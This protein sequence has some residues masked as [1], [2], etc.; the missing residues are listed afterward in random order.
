MPRDLIPSDKTIRAVRPGDSRRRLSDGDGLYLLLFVKGGSHGWRFDYS[1]GGKRKTLS[2]GVYPDTGLSLARKKAQDARTLLQQGFDPSAA[3]REAKAEVVRK[4]EALTRE[5]AGLPPEGSF[6]AVARAWLDNVHRVDCVA[7][8]ADRTQ[9]RLEQNVFPWLGRRPIGEIEPPEL[10]RCLR[11]IEERGARETA[12]RV[13]F[14]CSQVF[15]YG[16]AEG[17]CSRDPASDLRDALASVTVRHHAAIVDPAR[18]G[19]LLRAIESYK[20][21][22]VTRAALALAPLVFQR[23]GELR[24]A[25]WT[26]FDLEAATWTIPSAR[27]K[28]RK[29]QKETGQPHLV[30]LSTQ[31]VEILN[32]LRPLTGQGRF[33][34]P[35]HRSRAR[36]MSDAAV[37]AA[38][39]RMG[40]PKDE[41]SGHGFRAMARTLLAERLAVPPEVIEAQLAHHVPDALG[42]AYNRALYV[43]Q[44]RDMMQRWADYLDRLRRGAEVIAF[45][46]ASA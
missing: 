44:R 31:A 37:L 33:V 26:E 15:R 39:R 19:E 36:P 20:G 29:Q 46:Q 8:H 17:H 41:M 5:A 38:L 42:R 27:M 45:K 35:G 34:F 2:L 32:D 3:R 22:A 14:A 7:A 4:V 43:E 18:V 6:E 28:W 1:F 24:L 9:A 21:H 30:P 12:H 10:L 11:R 23:P 40:Y 16:I 13:K 25:E